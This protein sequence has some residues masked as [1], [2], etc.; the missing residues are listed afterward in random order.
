VARINAHRQ[1]K[2]TQPPQAPP[3]PQARSPRRQDSLPT[4]DSRGGERRA[5]LHRDVYAAIRKQGLRQPPNLACCRDA[6]AMGP[7]PEPPAH[8]SASKLH[9]P[10]CRWQSTK[11]S[12]LAVLITSRAAR[13]KGAP[14]QHGARPKGGPPH[15]QRTRSGMGGQQMGGSVGGPGLLNME[16]L[17]RQQPPTVCRLQA[18]RSPQGP[19]PGCEPC[20]PGINRAHLQGQGLPVGPP[21]HIP[22]PL[23]RPGDADAPASITPQ[24]PW[25]WALEAPGRPRRR[26]SGRP[27]VT[28]SQAKANSKSPAPAAPLDRVRI[29]IDSPGCSRPQWPAPFQTTT[30]K[31]LSAI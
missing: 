23:S 11:P 13:L 7:W 1:G 20:R 18:S 17:D 29:R 22:R 10:A 5:C 30:F 31:T 27:G 2:P 19:A 6:A 12:R 15:F 26:Q 4:R 24:P 28:T 9:P 16:I 8:A 25:E 21:P 3:P 14:E